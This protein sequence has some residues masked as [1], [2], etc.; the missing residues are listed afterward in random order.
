MSGLDSMESLS[1][2]MSAKYSRSVLE[3]FLNINGLP[4][5]LRRYVASLIKKMKRGKM[6]DLENV[7]GKIIASIDGIEIYR[8]RYSLDDFKKQVLAGKIG[9][10]CQIAIHKDKTSGE[11]KYVEIYHRLV[12]IC[13]ITDRGP[14]PLAWSYQES[15]AGEQFAS[16]LNSGADPAKIPST[17][18]K[19]FEKIK[20]E[21]EITTLKK[22][23]AELTV[24]FPRGLP[25]DVLIGDGLYD[26]S[27]VLECVEE[28]GVALIAVHKD[29]RRR[30]RK[31]AEDDFSTRAPDAT[32][33]ERQRTFEGWSKVYED[34]NIRPS[35]NEEFSERFL[36]VTFLSTCKSALIVSRSPMLGRIRRCR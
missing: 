19:S 2:G 32:W 20:Q 25:F 26:K 12:V 35:K 11:I 36:G 7:K 13:I 5:R 4:R 1:K 33:S 10:H 29:E 18:E 3:S 24:D 9:R 30:L 14:M 21:G 15:G 17:D 28:Y 27:T 22:I 8:K 34:C 23:L 6:I 16:W 31:E